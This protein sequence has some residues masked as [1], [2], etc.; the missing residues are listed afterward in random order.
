MATHT[1]RL[2]GG[3]LNEC[4][5]K[6]RQNFYERIDENKHAAVYAGVFEES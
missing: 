2:T 6:V 3:I 1:V 4:F 5:Q